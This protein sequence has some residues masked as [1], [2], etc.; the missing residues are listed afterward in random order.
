MT[1]A[2]LMAFTNG[3]KMAAVTTLA[4]TVTTP[5]DQGNHNFNIHD[6][7]NNTILNG[8]KVGFTNNCYYIHDKRS[9]QI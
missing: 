9:I 4:V 7:C 6:T 1:I 2:L 3:V 8:D 5:V